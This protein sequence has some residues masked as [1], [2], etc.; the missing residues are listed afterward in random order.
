VIYTQ[1]N[2]PIKDVVIAV[3]TAIVA[4]EIVEEPAALI[5]VVPHQAIKVLPRML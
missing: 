5:T 2:S 1:I 3:V 4:V